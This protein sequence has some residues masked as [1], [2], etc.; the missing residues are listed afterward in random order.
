MKNPV[1]LGKPV[2]GKLKGD[3][4]GRGPPAQWSALAWAPGGPSS[5]PSPQGMGFQRRGGQSQSFDLLNQLCGTDRIIL[6]KWT[7]L[8]KMEKERKAVRGMGDSEA[9]AGHD[10]VYVHFLRCV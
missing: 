6:E 5:E 1:S 7:H 9:P 10:C 3:F 8:P 2:L 4:D